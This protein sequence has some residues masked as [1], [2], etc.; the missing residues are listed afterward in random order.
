MT[1]QINAD[2][3]PNI[4][5]IVIGLYELAKHFNG[6]VDLVPSTGQTSVVVEPIKRG[7][8]RPAKGEDWCPAPVILAAAPAATS[9]ADP[10][11]SA[12]APAVPAATL[13]EVRASLKA[14]A[15]ATSQAKA[16]EVLKAVGGSANLTDLPAGKYGLVK[17]AAEKA[18]PP[19]KTEPVVEEDPF[20]EPVAEQKQL[21]IEDV[22][23]AI[24]AAQKRTS[25][26][27]VQKLV[28]SFGGKAA[29]SSGAQAPSMKAL[30][31]SQYAA[32]IA[33][34]NA[35]PTTK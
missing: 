10:F 15:A 22:K 26:N 21:T 14:L 12:P 2:C 7:R 31:E 32:T 17:Q 5:A 28:M 30:P 27:T 6:E 13:D 3:P 33:A 16:L 1:I 8:G 9:E 11:D 25:Q 35:L 24:V 29:D 18:L 4:Q 19:V 34:L 23:A 20:D